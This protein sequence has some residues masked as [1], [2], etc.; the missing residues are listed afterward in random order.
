MR[1]ATHVRINS[2]QKVRALQL[3]NDPR[4]GISIRSVVVSDSR[5]FIV[6][7]AAHGMPFTIDFYPSFLNGVAGIS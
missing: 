1:F 3:L 2:E 6:R 5:C 7:A 4:L